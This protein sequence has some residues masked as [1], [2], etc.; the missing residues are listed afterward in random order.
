MFIFRKEKYSHYVNRTRHAVVP[1]REVLVQVWF[2][3][4]RESPAHVDVRSTEQMDLGRY[5]SSLH[6][7][8]LISVET[9]RSP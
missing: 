1:V 4:S 5:Y 7:H 8:S 2:W 3:L 6:L 9:G